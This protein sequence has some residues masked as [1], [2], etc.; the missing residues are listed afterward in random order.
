MALAV[1]RMAP[2]GL[3]RRMAGGLRGHPAPGPAAGR[4]LL[5]PYLPCV[6]WPHALVLDD[7]LRRWR[8]QGPPMGPLT[9]GSRR[10]ASWATLRSYPRRRDATDKAA[11]PPSSP[12]PP[13]PASP[14][15]SP[16]APSA[17]T[18]A[19]DTRGDGGNGSGAWAGLPP[20][21]RSSL[22]PPLP[23]SETHSPRSRPRPAPPLPAPPPP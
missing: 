3:L 22:P 11:P 21:T 23:P 5:R 16:A 19:P 14:S 15:P 9:S 7:C 18:T 6:L 13:P 17:E 2:A 10:V 8:P 1:A 20:I 4:R 12:P